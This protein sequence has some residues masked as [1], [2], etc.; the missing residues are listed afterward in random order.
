MVYDKNLIT[1]ELV[2]QRFALASTPESL[3]ATRAMGKSFAG[4]DFEAGMMWREVYRLR[5]PVLLIW[6]VRTGSTRW[7]ARWLR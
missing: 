3:T 2:D 4:A 1:P 5:Q 7:T 6:V